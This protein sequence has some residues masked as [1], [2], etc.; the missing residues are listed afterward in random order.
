MAKPAD[1]EQGS[2][3]MREKEKVIYHYV[4]TGMKN[5]FMVVIN[6]KI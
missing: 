5:R 1:E 6:L 2:Q 4:E 3:M